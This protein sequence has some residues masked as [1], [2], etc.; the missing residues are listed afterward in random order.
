M[1]KVNRRQTLADYVTIA[2]SPLLIMSLIGSLVFFLLEVLYA[3]QYMGRMQ[4]TFFFLIMGLVLVAR[5]S[6]ELGEARARTYG[7]ILAVVAFLALQRFM[8]LDETTSLAQVSWLINAGLVGLIW[9]CASKLTW[10]STFI[11]D[12]IDASGKGVLEAAGL[13][14][15]AEPE[16]EQEEDE[17]S[18]ANAGS[19]PK[20]RSQAPGLL[21]W[22]DRYRDYLDK[23][24]ERP[25]APGVWVV[26]F[27]L[28]ALPLFGLGQALIPPNEADRRR[29]ALWLLMTY[30]ASGLGLLVTTNFLGLRRYLRQRKLRMPAS[31]AATWLLIA[32]VMI[33]VLLVA[34]ELMPRPYGEYRLVS[35]SGLKSTQ[36]L[37]SR[38]AFKQGDPGKSQGTPSDQQAKEDQKAEPGPGT[39]PEH[40]DNGRPVSNKDG[41]E[42]GGNRG[43][44]K[45]SGSTNKQ[46]TARANRS[47]SKGGNVKAGDKSQRSADQNRK[48][49]NEDS[50]RNGAEQTRS[51]SLRTS[52]ENIGRFTQALKWIVFGTVVAILIAWL[53]RSGL[54]FLANF[55]DWAR[56]LL[57]ALHGWWQAL[58]GGTT[59]HEVVSQ[60]SRN[61]ASKSRLRPFADFRNPFL[62]GLAE[63]LTPNELVRYSFDALQSWAWDR[64]LARHPQETPIEFAD[65]LAQEV[66]ALQADCQRVA[67][68]YA[69]VAYA[70]AT[71]GT[72][73]LD[74]VRGF[75]DRLQAVQERPLSA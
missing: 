7:S 72:G 15:E 14:F 19:K 27:S 29:Y 60:F 58:F 62:D 20:P 25:H 53:L 57:D 73:T 45:D 41:Q 13:D 56:R 35:F 64:D 42:G 17:K 75:W 70:R 40:D 63:Q 39:K 55:T 22:W 1:A 44:S 59:T 37:A 46:S 24:S 54:R 69:R 47:D 12:K 34:A 33:L 52:F 66:P 23:R 10:D 18:L 43:E 2:L 71:L 6:I 16:N 5:V 74:T 8:S 30:L 36:R 65:R 31:M 3:G 28:A 26:Y 51:S 67:S 49:G 32:G 9:W 21:G 38:Q 11:D 48:S 4:W 61:D 68:L 50:D